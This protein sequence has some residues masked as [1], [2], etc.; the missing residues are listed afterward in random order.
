MNDQQLQVFKNNHV[1]G[2]NERDRAKR[3]ALL[4]E[5][6]T[7]DI[8]MYDENSVFDG[9]NA[10]SDFIGQLHLQDPDFLFFSD[11]PMDSVQNSIRFFGQIR[12]GQGLLNS[13]DF[14]LL[15]DGKAAHLYAYMVPAK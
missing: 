13:M 5:I 7:Q 2:W 14:F 6:Y 4:G 8:K 9:L 10:I 1:D 12:T 3:D 15:K 11:K